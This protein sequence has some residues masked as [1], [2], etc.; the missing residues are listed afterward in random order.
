M[1]DRINDILKELQEL[2]Q[3]FD[4]LHLEVLD[5]ASDVRLTEGDSVAAIDTG[6]DVQPDYTDDEVFAAIKAYDNE[7]YTMLD[8]ERTVSKIL[9][10]TSNQITVR[11]HK[12]SIIAR[13]SCLICAK[14]KNGS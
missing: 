12:Q 2:F 7:Q 11:P 14:T 6:W 10:S 8:L 13:C 4:A 5:M 1:R 3:K 9:K